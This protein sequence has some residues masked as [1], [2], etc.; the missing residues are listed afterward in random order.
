[1]KILI[2]GAGWYGCYLAT[3]LQEKNHDVLLVDK[4]DIFTQSSYNNQNRLHLGFHYPRSKE[5]IKECQRGYDLFMEK[6]P[7]LT[8]EIPHNYYF[9]ANDSKTNLQT[10][11]NTFTDFTTVDKNKVEPF[12]ITNIENEALIV[13]ER[14]INFEKARIFFTSLLSLSFEKIPN[15]NTIKEIKEFLQRDFDLTINC[16]YNELEPIDYDYYEIFLSFIYKIPYE[17]LFGYTVMDG[18]YFS[19]F[20]YKPKESLFSLTSVKNGVAYK[21]VVIEDR[22]ISKEKE[23]NI[24]K[25]CE[26]EIK[27]YIPNFKGEYMYFTKSLKTKPLTKEDDRSLR[28]K[29][30][31][32]LMTFYGGKIT[33]IFEAEKILSS[34]IT[35]GKSI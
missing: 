12:Q 33:G 21:G 1:M 16:T 26:E 32:I 19:L 6:F 13:N 22:E 28:Y 3:V 15:F 10:F 9:V 29:I 11:K 23:E 17:T 5:T 7:F 2:I 35:K 24:R 4:N 31:N 18:N 25:A 14:Y 34:F 30:E 20:P 8:E 27:R